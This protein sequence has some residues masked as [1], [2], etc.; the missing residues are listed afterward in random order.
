MFETIAL[1]PSSYSFKFCE[2]SKCDYSYVRVRNKY[3]YQY[4]MV[5]HIFNDV[6]AKT[7]KKYT[8]V[9]FYI[10]GRIAMPS[11]NR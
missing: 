7:F 2:V 9:L 1:D 5:F 3:R 8:Q 10:G 6:I 11:L 4:F